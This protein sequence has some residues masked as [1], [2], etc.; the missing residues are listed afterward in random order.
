MLTPRACRHLRDG[1]DV[2][3]REIRDGRASSP[4]LGRPRL[5]SAPDS[6]LL[7]VAWKALLNAPQRPKPL[8]PNESRFPERFLSQRYERL[9][10]PAA[11]GEHKRK[12]ARKHRLPTE[13]FLLCSERLH[14]KPDEEE[15]Q[16][17]CFT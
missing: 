7:P 3:W 8:L 16:T 4:A 5:L 6:S 17:A 13:L 1:N 14:L 10:P 11:Y 9:V 15:Y 2:S 12:A